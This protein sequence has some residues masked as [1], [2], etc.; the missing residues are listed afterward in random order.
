MIPFEKDKFNILKN[1]HNNNGH[2]GINRTYNKI[3]ENGYFWDNII[4][5]IKNYIG[6]CPNC[7]KIKA[8]KKINAKTK[9]IITKGPLERVVIDGWELDQN[10]KDI[11][12]Y[13]WVIDMIVHFSKFL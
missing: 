6:N 10:L 2:L 1:A 11:T 4:N 5:D 9:V 13:T 3:K 7:I 12:G 8:G